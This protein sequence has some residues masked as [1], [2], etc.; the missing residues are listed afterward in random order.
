M[1]Q[2]SSRTLLGISG[3]LVAG[4]D[5]CPSKGHT[6]KIRGICTRGQWFQN[7]EVWSKRKL[8]RY[9]NLNH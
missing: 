4:Q 3:G 1:D 7:V 6:Y 8:Q 2:E 9:C 5:L